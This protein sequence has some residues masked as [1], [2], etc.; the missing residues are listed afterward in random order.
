MATSSGPRLLLSAPTS[1]P[2]P[3]PGRPLPQVPRILV[4]GARGQMP[5]KAQSQE[6][7]GGRRGTRWGGRRGWYPLQWKCCLLL[8]GGRA[9]LSRPQPLGPVWGLPEQGSRGAA[10]C[11][12]GPRRDGRGQGWGGGTLA[13]L[14]SP[15]QTHPRERVRPL[16]VAVEVALWATQ[17]GPR[18]G[19]VRQPGVPRRAC[20]WAP[21]AP[22]GGAPSHGRATTHRAALSSMAPRGL[23]RGHPCQAPAPHPD[24]TLGLQLFQKERRPRGREGASGT[25]PQAWRGRLRPGGTEQGSGPLAPPHAVHAVPE[26]AGGRA[27]PSTERDPSC[28]LAPLPPSQPVPAILRLWGQRLGG[29]P[30]TAPRAS[31]PVQGLCQDAGVRGRRAC[32]AGAPRPFGKR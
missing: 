13:L 9:A 25:V 24:G 4:G 14:R 21:L 1:P 5:T 8:R 28:E 23:G 20:A 6:G 32:P 17:P 3:D 11:P 10:P 7:G 27:G 31:T 16:S 15:A 30:S 12:L 18:E 22:A 29:E 26:G 19:G 2:I